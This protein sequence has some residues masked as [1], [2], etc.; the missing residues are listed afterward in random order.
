MEHDIDAALADARGPTWALIGMSFFAVAREG[1][2]SVFFLL[3]IFQ[4]S[5]GPA[6]PV[7]ALLGIA[8]RG[9]CSATAST[10]AASGSTSA[11]SSAGPGSSSSSSPPASPP[12]VLRN[13]HEAGIWN[14]LQQ[15]VWDLTRALPVSSVARHRAERAL[16][17][18]RRAGARRGAW[19]GRSSS[20][21]RLYFFLRPAAAA[22]QPAATGGLSRWPRR[23]QPVSRRDAGLALA[24]AGAARRSPA[25][26][27]F[28][29][30]ARDR[31]SRADRRRDRGHRDRRDLRAGRR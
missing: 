11:A 30:A 23:P 12:A 4:Q 9:R 29:F 6:A 1:L 21:S 27:A 31:A 14:H 19:S 7:G 17:L 13:L 5:P 25:L 18:P 28:W 2:E 3:A 16:R 8:V 22:R 15:P 20:A 26:A 10:A 24:G